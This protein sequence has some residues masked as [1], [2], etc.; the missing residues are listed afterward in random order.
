MRI[1][2]TGGFSFNILQV[3]VKK[4]MCPY[5]D[6]RLRTHNKN[7]KSLVSSIRQR[8]LNNSFIHPSAHSE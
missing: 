3:Q 7:R 6:L 8:M 4:M 2:I 5:K 1:K